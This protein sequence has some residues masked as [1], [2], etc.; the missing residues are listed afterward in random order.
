M[1][2]AMRRLTLASPT[3]MRVAWAE[4]V[5]YRAEMVIWILTAT[6]PLVMLALWNAAAADGPIGAYGQ[7]EFAR[8]FAINL[9]VRQLTGC[10]VMW[11]LNQ[12]IRTGALSS[13]LLKPVHPLAF[14]LF[15]TLA[16]L[17]FRLVVLLPLV[18]A[19]FWWR[20][21]IAFVPSLLT[22]A[23]FA[24]SVSLALA[25][26][27]LI[28][29]L[30]GVLCFWF[31]Q[32]LGMFQA[33]FAVWAIMSGYFLPRDLLPASVG[34]VATWLPFHAALGA[35]IDLLMGVDPAPLRTLALQGGW[36]LAAALTV[37]ALWAAGVRRYGAFGA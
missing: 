23:M 15:E 34:A 17:P 4:I 30:F 36:V 8:Y 16:A 10:W 24:L 9:V 32:S 5:A 2:A 11:E 33:Y 25:L 35:P 1:I 6:L 14:N 7:V 12:L 13:W 22:V 18:G 28:Q 21:E 37:R 19:M 27:F 20:P 3:L 31:E 29:C 26:T